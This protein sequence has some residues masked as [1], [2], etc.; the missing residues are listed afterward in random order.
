VN[1]TYLSTVIATIGIDPNQLIRSVG[2]F[3][4]FVVVFA[5]SGLFIGF[6]LPGDSLL[7]TAGLL[8]ATTNLLSPFP[9][10]ILGCVVAAIV[11]DQVGYLFGQRFGARLFSQPDSRFLKRKHLERAEDFFDRHGSKTVLLARFV[12][13]VRTFAPIVAGASKMHWRTFSIYNV[14]GGTTWVVLLTGLGW[15]L[16]TRYPGIADSLDLAILAIVAISLVPL[17]VEYLRHR[18]ARTAN[19]ADD[20]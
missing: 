20:R 11:G 19:G 18:R 10:I 1:L 5:E 9:L 3:G 8:A 2:L 16:G 15:A 4:L 6:F 13:V 7:F 12:P 14:I 17:A